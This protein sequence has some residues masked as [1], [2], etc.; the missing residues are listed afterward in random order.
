MGRRKAPATFD[1]DEVDAALSRGDRSHAFTLLMTRYGDPVY[2]YALA[3]TGDAQQMVTSENPENARCAKK[4]CVLERLDLA[5]VVA[6]R[7]R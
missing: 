3:T 4:T 1:E 5:D 6:A 2:R 7:S